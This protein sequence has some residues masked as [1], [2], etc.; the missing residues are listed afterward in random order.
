[1]VT[2]LDDLVGNVTES[3]ISTGMN[4]NSIIIFVSDNGGATAEGGNNLPLRG[5]KTTV[6]E[7][8]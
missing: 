4:N 1:M 3:L 6:F 8:G 5:E 2:A 7:G